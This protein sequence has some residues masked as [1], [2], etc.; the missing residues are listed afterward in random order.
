MFK[1][2]KKTRQTHSKTGYWV[3]LGGQ[4]LAVGLMIYF[5]RAMI[6]L[7]DT[8]EAVAGAW[9]KS[10]SEH[11]GFVDGL[12]AIPVHL[13]SE[14]MYFLQLALIVFV[15]HLTVNR[16]GYGDP[17]YVPYKPNHGGIAI[18]AAMTLFRQ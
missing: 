18:F 11:F 9:Q 17:M 16:E 2:F 1:W 12:I 8:A 5:W 7:L 3:H 15:L 14:P 6:H 10:H 13:V 4:W